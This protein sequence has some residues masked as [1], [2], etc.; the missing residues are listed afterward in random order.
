MA[1][2]LHRFHACAIHTHAKLQNARTPSIAAMASPSIGFSFDRGR[3][4]L[5][6]ASFSSIVETH[7]RAGD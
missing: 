2:Y 4:D 7:T 3:K 5:V 1:P 6:R